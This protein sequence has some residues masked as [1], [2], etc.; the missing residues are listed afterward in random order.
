MDFAGISSLENPETTIQ[1]LGLEQSRKN[2]ENAM[3]TGSTLLEFLFWDS[4]EA[5]RQ[6]RTS[7]GWK[8]HSAG[9]ARSATKVDFSAWGEGEFSESRCCIRIRQAAIS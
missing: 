5:P 2:T 6:R 4:E 3:E 8:P 1:A 9:K 7:N